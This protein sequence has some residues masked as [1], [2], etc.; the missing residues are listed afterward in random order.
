LP[1]NGWHQELMMMMMMLAARHFQWNH[2][3]SSTL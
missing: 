3:E 2:L 1:P